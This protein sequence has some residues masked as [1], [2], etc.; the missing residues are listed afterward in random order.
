MPSFSRGMIARTA[1]S[2]VGVALSGATVVSDAAIGTTIGVLS[3]VG[4]TGTYSYALTDPSGL[5]VIAGSN[6]NVKAALSPGTYPI[7]VTAT[8]G[9]PSPLSEYL[10]RSRCC[11]SRWRRSIPHRR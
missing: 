8:G 4:G 9:T 5:F 3:V 2:S 11:R 6:L 10:W 1:M 7:T